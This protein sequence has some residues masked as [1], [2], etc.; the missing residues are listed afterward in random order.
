MLIIT[1]EVYYVL[2]PG[3]ILFMTV[4][5]FNFLY[6]IHDKKI[7]HYRR[8]TEKLAK[9]T[10]T[11]AGFEVEK[12]RYWNLLGFFGWL[13]NFKILKNDLKSATKYYTDVILG[14]CLKLESKLTMPIG[15]SIIIVAR[16]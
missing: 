13:I 2:K 16:K 3:G 11:N 6:S 9:Q 4:P 1:Q 7:G 8:Y 15:L 5:A 10:V 14:K 12:C